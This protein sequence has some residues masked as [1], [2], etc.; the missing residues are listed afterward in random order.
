VLCHP[1]CRVNFN[2]HCDCSGMAAS[3]PLASRRALGV[4]LAADLH[5]WESTCNVLSAVHTFR[6]LAC[7]EVLLEINCFASWSEKPGNIC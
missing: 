3:V 4:S 5:R 2:T 6:Q 7:A 1:M